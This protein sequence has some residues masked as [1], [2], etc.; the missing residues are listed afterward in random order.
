MKKNEQSLRYGGQYK[1]A[2]IYVIVSAGEEMEKGTGD[3]FEEIKP[4]PPPI[5]WKT[6]N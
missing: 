5:L 2:D 1:G 6:L 3:I 4:K